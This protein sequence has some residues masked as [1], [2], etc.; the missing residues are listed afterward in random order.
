MPS[1]VFNGTV[2]HY[3]VGIPQQD[4]KHAIIFVHGAGGNHKYWIYQTSELGQKFLTFAVDLPGHG[5]SA[6]QPCSSIE[7]YCEF[8]YD[9][10][11]RTVGTKFYLAGHSMGGAIAMQFALR[12]PDR[13]NGLILIGTGARL[14]VVPAIL[15][16]FAAGQQFPD[17]VHLAYGPN[18]STDLISWAREEIDYTDP[19][20]YY[21]DFTACNNF[22]IME[23]LDDIKVPAL[24][25]GAA[26]DRLTPPKYSEYLAANINHTRLHIIKG[27]GHMMMLENPREVNRLIEQFI[28]K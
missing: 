27:A 22:D 26:E 4:S 13:L 8:I 12:Y 21:K 16:T 9:F 1:V 10:A 7:D 3:T 14:K 19:K 28:T 25:L 20:I 6:G 11:E 24:V 23:Q 2:Y 17:L 18:T 15:D 5:Q